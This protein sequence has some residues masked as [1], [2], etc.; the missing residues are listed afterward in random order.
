MSNK[1]FAGIWG[2]VLAILLVALIVAN[3]VALQ[4]ATIITR[5]LGH[6]TVET[7]NMDT[8]GA[9]DYFTSDYSSQEELLAHEVAISQQIEAEG[10]VL[11]K[12][13]QNALPIT[14]GSKVTFLSLASTKFRYGGGGSGAIDDTA[15]QSLKETF[16]A[17]GFEV[18]HTVWEMYQAC[19]E[20]LPYEIAPSDFSQ[21]VV[22][23][24]RAITMRLS[25]CSPGPDTR[26]PT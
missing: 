8:S 20:R 9:S 16:E 15:V 26:R 12:N 13:D 19:E 10:A 7:V 11:L 2:S 17:E 23:S 18:N 25:L 3:C 24:C 5:S 21:A 14:E 1:L 6:D 4:Y 22:D